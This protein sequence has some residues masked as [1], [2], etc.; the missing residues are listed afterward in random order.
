[1]PN[2]EIK[3]NKNNKKIKFEIIAAS[4]EKMSMIS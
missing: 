1:V 2:L 3:N 4:L